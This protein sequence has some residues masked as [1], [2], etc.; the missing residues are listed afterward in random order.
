MRDSGSSFDAHP[1]E[2]AREVSRRVSLLF[3]MLEKV[4]REVIIGWELEVIEGYN[5]LSVSW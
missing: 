1:A 5:G 4:L 3:M 2:D